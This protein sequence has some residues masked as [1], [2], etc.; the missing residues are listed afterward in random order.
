MSDL[1]CCYSWKSCN[2]RF[3]FR[4]SNLHE[5][6]PCVTCTAYK[7][8]KRRVEGKEKFDRNPI[9]ASDACAWSKSE[10]NQYRQ[11]GAAG[12]R[13]AEAIEQFSVYCVR[14]CLWSSYFFLTISDFPST[15]WRRDNT[16]IISHSLRNQ[17]TMTALVI[18]FWNCSLTSSLY[19]RRW[20]LSIWVAIATL[21]RN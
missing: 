12:E 15:F 19:L 1:S 5:L 10:L 7:D 21:G 6:P 16:L 4:Q 18:R 9:R 11:S 2:T 3:T 14:A 13:R 17:A 8:K 20:W